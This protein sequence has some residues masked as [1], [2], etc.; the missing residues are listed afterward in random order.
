MCVFHMPTW[1]APEDL[2]EKSVL[3]QAGEEG[4]N[5]GA[6][7]KVEWSQETFR[8]GKASWAWKLLESTIS[9]RLERTKE[10]A[11]WEPQRVVAISEA[12][13]TGG[14]GLRKEGVRE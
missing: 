5:Q 4:F 7:Y 9:P 6:A 10:G 3:L 13:R 14:F 11:V 8:A 12:T 1:P 2:S